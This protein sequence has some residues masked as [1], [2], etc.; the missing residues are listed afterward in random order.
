[1]ALTKT[2]SKIKESQEVVVMRYVKSDTTA[3]VK[4]TKHA[5]ISGAVETTNSVLS[6]SR[7]D[8]DAVIIS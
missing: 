8:K 3:A 1:M 2:M 7:A 5:S 6:S 4:T